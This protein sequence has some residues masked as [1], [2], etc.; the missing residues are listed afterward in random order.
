[1]WCFHLVWALWHVSCYSF[2]VVDAAVEEA[3]P[4]RQ[5]EYRSVYRAAGAQH[6][7]GIN[8]RRDMSQ[9]S[10]SFQMKVQLVVSIVMGVPPNGWLIMEHPNLESKME[11][12][13]GTPMTMETTNWK[14]SRIT[15][16]FMM[17]KGHAHRFLYG[18]FLTKHIRIQDYVWREHWVFITGFRWFWWNQFD[19]LAHGL[20]GHLLET[21][22]FFAS[23]L[24]I[25]YC[26]NNTIRC[27]KYQ[28][29][30]PRIASQQ[31]HC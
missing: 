6:L 18:L 29:R 24:L 15:A 20:Q 10:L 8:A 1:M 16:E 31:R 11:D 3:V 7:V 17:H 19:A 21:R 22:F 9:W 28:C 5:N 25:E 30:S 27:N 26:S 12:F 2:W 14:F 13:G 23:C 4:S